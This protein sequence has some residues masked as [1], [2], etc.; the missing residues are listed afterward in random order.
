M[1]DLLLANEGRNDCSDEAESFDNQD[2][3]K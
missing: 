1:K 2:G 3:E